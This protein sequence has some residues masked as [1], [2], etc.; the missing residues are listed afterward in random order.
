MFQT[1]LLSLLLVGAPTRGRQAPDSIASII[2][3]LEA[4]RRAAHLAGDGRQLADI[5]AD[6]F[7]D[8]AAN[9]THRTKQQSVDET[10][11]GVIRW[12]TLVARNEHVT[13]FD[14]VAAVI[15]GEQEASGTY[16]GQ[17]FS[18]HVRY[19][20]VYLKRRGRWQNVA[21]QNSLIAP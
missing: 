18:R 6:D 21:A 20:R 13:V 17:P 1:L 10:R 12:T 4:P 2:L 5:L 8:V 9:G 19:M 7:V 11:R 16:D 14:S 15:T 3:H